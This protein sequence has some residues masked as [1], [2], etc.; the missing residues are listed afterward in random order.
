[1]RFILPF[2]S[3]EVTYPHQGPRSKLV[4]GKYPGLPSYCRVS[5]LQI[6][7][8]LVRSE[9]KWKYPALLRNSQMGEAI[10]TELV[11]VLIDLEARTKTQLLELESSKSP[12]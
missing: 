8:R 11:S 2:A 12:D 5:Q 7:V 3:C 4:P 10:L 6:E 1:M 9:L